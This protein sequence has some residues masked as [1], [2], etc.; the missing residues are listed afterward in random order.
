[1]RVATVKADK[2]ENV[3]PGDVVTCSA[4]LYPA[5]AAG[6]FQWNASPAGS[7]APTMSTEPTYQMTITESALPGDVKITCQVSGEEVDP[8]N[9]VGTVTFNVVAADSFIDKAVVSAEGGVDTLAVGD[10]LQLIANIT[11]GNVDPSKYTV[12]WEAVYDE[13]DNASVDANGLLTALKAGSYGVRCNISD[14]ETKKA[15]VQSSFFNLTINAARSARR[16]KSK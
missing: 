3:R 8:S 7:V 15:L 14:A 12:S 5:D 16:K 11:P 1:M 9:D 6:E 10:T 4:V 13:K 2:V